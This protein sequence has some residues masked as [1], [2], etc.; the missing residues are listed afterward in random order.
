MNFS[1]L[2]QGCGKAIQTG[3]IFVTIIVI[4]APFCYAQKRRPKILPP[5][6]AQFA[7][8]LLLIP[9]DARPISWQLPR[10]VARVA[11]YEIVFPPRELLGDFAKPMD[12]DGIIAWAKKLDYDQI[13]G[14]IVS[15]DGLTGVASNATPEQATA[16]LE[17][18]NWLRQRKADLPIYGFVQKPNDEISKLV[19]DATV[20]GKP[21]STFTFVT[22]DF[23]KPVD[24]ILTV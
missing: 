23:L 22:T 6:N 18:V 2:K 21:T 12:A 11:D 24:A 14:V 13:N 8:K 20:V 17:F 3:L 10:L 15:L 5:Q 7:G 19:F 9:R 4:V 16:R 1:A